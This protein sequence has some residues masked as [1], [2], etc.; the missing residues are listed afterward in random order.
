MRILVVGTGGVGSA[1]AE[2]AKR[3]S[4]FEH[5]ALSDSDP[6]RPEHVVGELDDGRFSAHR[7]DAAFAAQPFLDKLAEHGA[8]HGVLELEP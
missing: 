5:C 2:I 3:R 1:F 7:I 6:A 8:P 4:F